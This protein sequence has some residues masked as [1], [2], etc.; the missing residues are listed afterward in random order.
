MLLDQR[1]V[2]TSGFPRVTASVLIGL[3]PSGSIVGALC[4]QALTKYA[5]SFKKYGLKL[6]NRI[7]WHFEHGLHA[8]KRFSGRYETILWFTKS[9]NY[10]FHLDPV[11]IPAKYPGKRHFKG[12]NAGRLSGHPLGKNPEDVWDIPNVK[13]NH[14]Q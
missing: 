12:P 7:M 14:V 10:T 11:R 2:T 3:W 8:S 9:D 6:R 5:R 1:R 13:N 4:P